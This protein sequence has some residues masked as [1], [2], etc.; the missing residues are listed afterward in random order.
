[1]RSGPSIGK[2]YLRLL[3]VDTGGDASLITLESWDTFATSCA[4]AVK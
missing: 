3:R 2:T 1:V 4:V